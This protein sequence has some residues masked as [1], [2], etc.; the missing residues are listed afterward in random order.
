MEFH[1]PQIPEGI[2]TDPDH[3]P[4]KDL[5][6]LLTTAAVLVAVLTAILVVSGGWLARQIPF[7]QEKQLA[8]RFADYAAIENPNLRQY[9]NDLKARLVAH[10]DLPAGMEITLHYVDEDTVNAFATLGGH[11]VLYR[12]LLE[13]MPDENTLA[14]VLAHEIA[15]VKHRDPIVALSRGLLVSTALA[16]VIGRSPAPLDQTAMLTLLSYGR[17]METAADAQAAGTLYRLYGHLG[18]S[19]TLFRLFQSSPSGRDSSQLAG[20]FQTH[21][22]NARRIEALQNLAQQNGWP[23][24]GAKTPLPADFKRWLE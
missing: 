5:F 24:D 13:T 10:S 3:S 12:G 19:Q 9:L 17:D 14:M 18:G 23:L 22:L 1:N 4:L 7:A 11:I 6:W 16:S 2:N 21:P 15:H 20:F 8:S